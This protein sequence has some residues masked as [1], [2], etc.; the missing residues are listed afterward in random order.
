MKVRSA[1]VHRI[2]RISQ[3]PVS[4]CRSDSK[5]EASL[6]PDLARLYSL[7]GYSNDLAPSSTEG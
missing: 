4:V 6:A 2:T 3:M 5:A 1:Q 7:S